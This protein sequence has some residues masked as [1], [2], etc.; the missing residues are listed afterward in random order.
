MTN[1][2]IP[3]LVTIP[4]GS[5]QFGSTP[6]D[7]L[8][9]ENEKNLEVIDLPFFQ[10]S[11]YPITN[12]QYGL[13]IESTNHYSPAHWQGTI[14]PLSLLNHPVVNISLIDAM[15]YCSWLSQQTGF[16]FTLPTEV[17]W[18]KA[19]RGDADNRRYVWGD[20]WQSS[21]CNT[22]ELNIGDTTDVTLFEHVNMSPFGVV[23]ILGNVWE[24]TQSYYRYRPGSNHESVRYGV[25][26]NV[27]RGGSWHND[28]TLARISCRGRYIPGIK[29]LY[30]GFRIVT[31]IAISVNEEDLSTA[32][33]TNSPKG[34]SI[35]KEVLRKNIIKYFSRNELRT[36]CFDMDIN[37]D[38]FPEDIIGFARELINYCDMRN[39]L[40]D[41][42]TRL[43]A[44][45]PNINWENN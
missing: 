18:E 32:K 6:Y 42:L 11:K 2:A 19:A 43:R 36:L 15:S 27:V 38:L 41:L 30:L 4:A 39:K 10:I 8:A 3:D 21:A 25:T 1:I 14:P 37:A 12:A 7:P 28:Q 17:E 23:D 22:S 16:K 26:Y 9:N 31:H 34:T 13:F 24:W 29:R 20:E 45:R 33:F 40:N 5:F 35:N 44:E